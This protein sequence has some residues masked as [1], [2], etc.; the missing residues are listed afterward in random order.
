MCYSS[1]ADAINASATAQFIGIS[2][3]N[4]KG[5]LSQMIVVFLI[6]GAGIGMLGSTISM[7]KY[8]KV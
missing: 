6:L 3:L 7:R 2:I 4:L 5:I 1:V 8:L